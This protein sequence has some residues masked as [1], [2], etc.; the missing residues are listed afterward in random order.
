[1]RAAGWVAVTLGVAALAVLLFATEAGARVWLALIEDHSPAVQK[2]EA[3]GAQAIVV[4]G[5]NRNRVHEA[6][7]L[8]ALTALPILLSGKGTGDSG[9]AAESEKMAEILRCVFR[10]S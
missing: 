6:A 3:A 2:Q 8:H 1:M 4:L 5:G 7:R 9:Y 10:R